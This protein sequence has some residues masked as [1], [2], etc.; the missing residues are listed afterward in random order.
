[1]AKDLAPVTSDFFDSA[2]QRSSTRIRLN[3]P[4]AAVFAALAEDPAGWG[5]WFPGFGRD[6]RYLGPGPFGV[7]TQ[8]QVSV[9]GMTCW[10]R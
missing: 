4:P 8:R 3:H 7:G 5:A 9:R 10:S 1:M 2:P 6:G